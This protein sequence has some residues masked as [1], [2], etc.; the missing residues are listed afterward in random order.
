MLVDGVSIGAAKTYTFTSINA[1]HTI[2]ASFASNTTVN[3]SAVAAK[4]L[5]EGGLG[6]SARPNPFKNNLTVM[7]TVAKKGKYDLTVTDMSG[8]VLSKQ[9]LDAS[10]GSNMTNLNVA[11][12]AGGSYFIILT[13]DS[14]TKTIKVIKAQ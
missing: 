7:F 13:G 2:S 6:L 12:Y 3:N 11:P 5:N 10:A 14:K 8:R 9:K 1:N 4:Q